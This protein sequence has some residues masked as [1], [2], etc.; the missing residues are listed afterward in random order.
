MTAPTQ[1]A[2]AQTPPQTSPA[3]GAAPT[4]PT[5]GVVVP[6]T[7]APPSA[8][9]PQASSPAAPSLADQR[10]PAGAGFADWM[11]GKTVAEIATLSNQMYSALQA[12]AGQ[13]SPA[14]VPTPSYP[15]YQ[16]PQYG[17]PAQYP[18]VTPPSAPQLP[19]QDDFITRPAEATK[20]YMEYM[21]ATEF[22]PALAQRDQMLAQ[23]ARDNVRSQDPEAFK[24][25][26][27]EIE[28]ALQQYAPDPM[29]RTPDNIRAVVDVV[30][31]RHAHEISEAEVE[32]RVQERLAGGLGGTLRSDSAGATTSVTG[33]GQLDLD[34]LPPQYGA[35]LKRLNLSQ[36]DIDNFLI[37]AKCNVTGCT[38]EQAR[39]EWVKQAS[40]GD[41][42]TD[43]KEYQSAVYA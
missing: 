17:Q 6:P 7:A 22:T 29:A 12:P 24:R 32:R 26:G 11:V 37:K 43:G 3:T 19:S 28:L 2:P 42:I 31:G 33:P 15:Q 35:A 5:N 14:P 20:Q 27:P 36:T 41:I 30:K 38:L 9:A 13:R 21:R 39:E 10:V 18:Q 1:T 8:T 34:K 16:P 25:W 4:S 23:L 40:R